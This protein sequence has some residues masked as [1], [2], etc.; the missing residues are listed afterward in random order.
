MINI[1]TFQFNE[2]NYLRL[3]H[4]TFSRFCKDPHRLICI[5]NAFD[6]L[7]QKE[8]I[9]AT[10]NELG[11]EHHFPQ[12]VNNAKG[13]WAHQTALNWTWKTLGMHNNDINIMLDHDMFLIKDFSCSNMQE[14]IWAI[15]Q[16]RGQHIKYFHPAFLV[17]NNTLRDKET[18]DFTGEYIDGIA[19]DSG[20]NWHHYLL[21]HPDLK[22]RGLAMPNICSDS[23]NLDL[24]PENVRAEYDEVDCL[25]IVEDFMIH[26][27]NGSNWA[28]NP[29]FGR[30]QEHLN[31][32]LDL[33]IK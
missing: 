8:A 11:I 2:P 6:N 14:D 16:G 30:K 18:I 15:M 13:G 10:A 31:Q 24:L 28:H 1:Y 25:Q 12:N 3:Q 7:Q 19:C 29:K 33:Y 27:R 23:G 21:K 22:I 26:F 9:R 5:N 17:M 20:G 32:I 4:K